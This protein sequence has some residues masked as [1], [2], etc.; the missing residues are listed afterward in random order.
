LKLL[1]SPRAVADLEEI[2]DYINPSRALSFLDELESECRSIASMPT[3]FT[4][5]ADIFPGI[6]MAVH[7][8]YLILFRVDK[9]A[10]RIERI[11]HGARELGA[12][13][14]DSDL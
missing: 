7:G 6:R 2:G 8:N 14:E 4:E 3:A 5:R 10:L 11:V 13:I 9:G 1:F 12:M